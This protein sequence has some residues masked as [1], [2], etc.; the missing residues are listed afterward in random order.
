VSR[1]EFPDEPPRHEQPF[2]PSTHK[3]RE[4]TNSNINNHNQPTNRS[5]PHFPHLIDSVLLAS[6]KNRMTVMKQSPSDNQL[7]LPDE[8]M[9]MDDD[10]QEPDE[11]PT[12]LAAA[13]LA[14][15]ADDDNES[16]SSSSSSSSVSAEQSRPGAVTTAASGA[17]HVHWQLQENRVHQIV[18]MTANDGCDDEQRQGGD[19]TARPTTTTTDAA[20][21]Q[22]QRQQAGPAPV[23]PPR[24]PLR[25][26]LKT[27]NSLA[28]S[29]GGNNKKSCRYAVVKSSSCCRPTSSSSS[30]CGSS[31]SN[32]RNRRAALRKRL[33]YYNSN[34]ECSSPSSATTTTATD[35]STG[36]LR[37]ELLRMHAKILQAARLELKLMRKAKSLQDRRRMLSSKYERLATELESAGCG[38]NAGEQEPRDGGFVASRQL[39]PFYE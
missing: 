18:E 37:Y 36:V 2:T 8:H 23:T 14:M 21:T 31:T 10:E 38:D 34:L 28:A 17:K 13:A 11:E 39:P 29:S 26:I 33:L 30:F 16:S 19:E 7:I 3:P 15:V 20:T 6:N 4:H 9:M 12:V 22:Q 32:R 35:E 27:K 25:G 1:A 24:V 5:A